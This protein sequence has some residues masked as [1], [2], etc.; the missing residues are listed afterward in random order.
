VRRRPREI[1]GFTLLELL[2]VLVLMSLMTALAAPRLVG[3]LSSTSAKASVKRI[4]AALRYARNQA[5]STKT[6]YAAAFHRE[7]SKVAVGRL[8]DP[9]TMESGELRM[10]D[11]R[12]F[13]LPDGIRIES[14]IP[15]SGEE[16]DTDPARIL[17]Y[18]SGASSGGRV[19]IADDRDRRS[20]LSVDPVM[21]TVRL[22]D[23]LEDQLED[24]MKN[25]VKR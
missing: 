4:A 11:P 24:R 8:P 18:P 15:A 25:R 20:G 16:D 6:V 12:V 7:S 3:T 9:R 22:E 1:G 17:F 2:V 10:F 14:V 23:Q 13:S 21:G 5:A 19:V